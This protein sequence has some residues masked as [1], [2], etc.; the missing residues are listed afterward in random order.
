MSAESL[1]QNFYAWLHSDEPVCVLRKDN[2][3]YHYVRVP[4]DANFDILYSQDTY[5]SDSNEEQL[6]SIK[7]RLSYAG[8]YCKKTNRIYDMQ[9]T[10]YDPLE[11]EEKEERCLLADLKKEFEQKIKERINQKLG[12]DP[13]QQLAV[14]RLFARDLVERYNQAKSF[15]AARDARIRYL[16]E[17]DPYQARFDSLKIWFEDDLIINEK[18]L[19]YILSPEE[20]IESEARKFIDEHQ[21]YLLCIAL[22]RKEEKAEYEKILN[23]PEHEAHYVR[24]IIAA[25]HDPKIKNVHVTLDDLSGDTFTFKMDADELRKDC[26]SGYVVYGL[27]SGKYAEFKAL[28]GSFCNSFSPKEIVRITYRKK[29]LYERQA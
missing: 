24:K 11:I 23:D 1:K 20:A 10:I 4:R 15:A 28:F 22:C 13:L 29:V 12:D 5:S 25:L 8:F 6:L 3:T 27:E 18:V 7:E 2:W 16:R 19:A 14:K 26:G 17:K 21:E 9:Y